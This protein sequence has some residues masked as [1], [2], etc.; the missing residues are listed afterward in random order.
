MKA[1]SLVLSILSMSIST[2]AQR[3]DVINQYL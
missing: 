1:I 2:L 3:Q